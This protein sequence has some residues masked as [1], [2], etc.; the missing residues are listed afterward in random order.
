MK[1]STQIGLTAA[2]V[3]LAA[4]AWSMLS[5]EDEKLVYADVGECKNAGQLP[6]G[7]CEARFADAQ[8]GHVRDAKKFSNTSECEAEY[9]TGRCETRT[10]NGV[11]MVVPA[12]AG[13][14][15]ARTLFGGGR[16]AEPLLPPTRQACPPGSQAPECQP[17]SRSSGTSSSSHVSGG[18][19][20]RSRAYTTMSGQALVANGGTAHA[21]VASR[22][23]FGSIGH[24]FGASSS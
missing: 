12:L 6:P 4:S 11:G 5:G 24:S 23:G 13:M 1:R 7:E 8:A 18:S 9:G 3:L 2:G 19:A 21:S 15:L 22:G 17:A 14:V 20:A 10:V 16:R